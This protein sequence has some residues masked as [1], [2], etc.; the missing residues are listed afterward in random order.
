M[1]TYHCDFCGELIHRD[2]VTVIHL[3]VTPTVTDGERID[4]LARFHL[5]QCPPCRASFEDLKFQ[6]RPEAISRALARNF[7]PKDAAWSQKCE[8]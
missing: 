5:E 7:R 8:K 6:D 2:L 4:P 3:L 1:I